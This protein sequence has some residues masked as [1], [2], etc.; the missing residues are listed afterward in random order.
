MKKFVIIFS[1]ILMLIP[2]LCGNKNS[3]GTSSKSQKQELDSF[4]GLEL[5]TINSENPKTNIVQLM[6]FKYEKLELKENT[7][8]GFESLH[9]FITFRIPHNLP[10][11]WQYKNQKSRPCNENLAYSTNKQ[12][13]EIN[14]SDEHFCSIQ[15]PILTNI[16]FRNLIYKVQTL[17]QVLKFKEKKGVPLN[18]AVIYPASLKKI[19]FAVVAN[20]QNYP[21]PFFYFH[22]SAKKLEE[23]FSNNFMRTSQVLIKHRFMIKKLSDFEL[24]DYEKFT[25]F[26]YWKKNDNNGVYLIRLKDDSKSEILAL[27]EKAKEGYDCLKGQEVPVTVYLNGIPILSEFFKTK[28]DNDG[29]I[30]KEIDVYHNCLEDYI[31]L[32]ETTTL[33]GKAQRIPFSYEIWV[34]CHSSMI[35]KD[36]LISSKGEEAE[37]NEVKNQNEMYTDEVSKREI[38]R[39]ADKNIQ[40]LRNPKKAREERDQNLWQILIIFVEKKYLKID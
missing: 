4:I 32:L 25:R 36:S 29:T 1:F 35:S 2:F 22:F 40:K 13:I 27:S 33:G 10:F 24:K 21:D 14:E 20:E 7:I 19:D 8:E 39:N 34:T 9:G 16:R 3:I 17:S 12:L 28:E 26:K 6:I 5:R 30:E 23:F 11:I 38:I 18:F 15:K 37:A 31:R